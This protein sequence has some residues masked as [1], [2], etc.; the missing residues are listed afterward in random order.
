MPVQP[1]PLTRLGSR[2]FKPAGTLTCD[3]CVT[4][5]STTISPS[6]QTPPPLRPLP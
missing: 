4:G 1:D 5:N 2:G 6:E 3:G